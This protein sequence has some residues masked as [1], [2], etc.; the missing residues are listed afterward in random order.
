M[1]RDLTIHNIMFK[2]KCGGTKIK[3]LT[4]S[5]QQKVVKDGLIGQLK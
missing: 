4:F 1:H 2:H 5:S 3:N